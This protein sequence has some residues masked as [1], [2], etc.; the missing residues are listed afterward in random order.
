MAKIQIR[1]LAEDIDN[2]VF[3]IQ[4]FVSLIVFYPTVIFSFQHSNTQILQMFIFEK[5][6]NKTNDPYSCTTCHIVSGSVL[7]ML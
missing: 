6:Q 1:P 5:T 3:L 2:N 7:I 4:I